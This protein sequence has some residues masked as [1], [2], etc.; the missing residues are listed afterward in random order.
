MPALRSASRLAD[1]NR[2]SHVHPLTFQSGVIQCVPW[3]ASVE[4]GTRPSGMAFIK[5]RNSAGIRRWP[6]CRLGSHWHQVT[7]SVCF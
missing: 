2:H 5:K 4:G 3:A 6:C 7:T 1:M